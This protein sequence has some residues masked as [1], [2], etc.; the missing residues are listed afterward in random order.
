LC[1]VIEDY[2]LVNFTTLNIQDKESVMDILKLID[3]SN[4]YVFAGIEGNITEFNKIAA[5]P[6]NWDYYRTAAVQEKYMKDD[7]DDR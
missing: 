4:G 2:S 5:A 1:E 6:L 3:K 7:E